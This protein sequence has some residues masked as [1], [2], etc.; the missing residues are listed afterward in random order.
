M[1]NNTTKRFIIDFLKNQKLLVIIV[2]LVLLLYFKDNRFLSYW[3][4]SDLFLHISVIGTMAVGMTLLMISGMLDLSVGAT[5]SLTAVVMMLTQKFGIFSSVL[6]GVLSAVMIGFLNGIIVV[7]GRINFFIATLGTMSIAKGLALALSNSHTVV[8]V[9]KSF[10]NLANGFI[11]GIPIPTIILIISY[12]VGGY[13]LKYSKL[14]RNSYTIGGNEHSAILAG[15]NVNKTRTLLFMFCALTAAIAGL[16]LSAKSNTGSANLGD[17]LTLIV[18]ATVV[19]GGASV[20]GGKGSM[21]GT[22][23]AAI[24]L[25]LVERAMIIFNINTWYQYMIRGII[26]LAVVVLDTY[27]ERK[28]RENK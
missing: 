15:V 21:I 18:I 19:L 26:I 7:K 2:V 9:N 8:G 27:F 16:I 24:I 20:F 12:L 17:N 4:I 13:L 5:L 11:L 3:S 28:N 25:G 6:L 22:F 1:E 23:Q 10:I 14:G